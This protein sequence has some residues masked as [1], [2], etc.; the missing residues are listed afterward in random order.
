MTR[1]QLDRWYPVLEAV[2]GVLLFLGFASLMLLMLTF[3]YVL[4]Y[5]GI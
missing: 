5:N 3:A 4:Y 1:E 2:W